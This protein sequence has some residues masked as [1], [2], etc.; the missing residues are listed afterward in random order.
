MYQVE[1]LQDEGPALREAVQKAEPFRPLMVKI[2]L[3]WNCNLAC[4]M[5]DYSRQ[6]RPTLLTCELLT[7]ALA[8]LAALGCRKVHFSGGEPTLRRDLPDL[9]AYA[10]RLK[11]RVTLTTNGTLLTPEL[12]KQLVKAGLNSVCVSIDSPRRSIHDRMRGMPGALKETVAGVRTLRRMAKACGSKLL[13]DG[14]S[15][16][17]DPTSGKPGPAIRINTV[18]C[19]ENYATLHELP[20]LAEAIGAQ[21]LL[22]MPVDDPSGALLLNKRR[23]LDYNRRIAPALADR[24]LALGLMRDAREAYPFGT[25]REELA[26]SREGNYARGLY[27]RQPCYAPW[28]HALINADACVA[29]CCSAPRMVLGDLRQQSFAEIWQGDA[30]GRLRQGMRDGMPLRNC[31]E[32]DMFMAENQTLYR[33]IGAPGVDE[34]DLES[35]P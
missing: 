25:T 6:A 13:S 20:D 8:D 4:G 28:M 21:E 19:R 14:P 17:D 16:N 9:I 10:R 2:K 33:W 12:C 18:V 15:L 30:Y 3:L 31:A 29:P 32:C 7:H 24:A 22:L 5:C 23:L 35:T 11:L 27:E 26:A 1:R 34:T